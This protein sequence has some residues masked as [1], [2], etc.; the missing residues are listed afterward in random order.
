MEDKCCRRSLGSPYKML[1]YPHNHIKHCSLSAKWMTSHFL[2][3]EAT[4]LANQKLKSTHRGTWTKR[5]IKEST[6]VSLSGSPSNAWSFLIWWKNIDTGGSA[7]SILFSLYSLPFIMNSSEGL[8]T[9][10]NTNLLCVRQ[11]L[12]EVFEQLC[13]INLSFSSPYVFHNRAVGSGRQCVSI[14]FDASSPVFDETL[15]PAAQA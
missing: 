2:L 8:Q 12:Q 1:I 9:L 14:R 10:T 5:Y 3:T 13:S 7:E 6:S 15:N 11:E 4:Q